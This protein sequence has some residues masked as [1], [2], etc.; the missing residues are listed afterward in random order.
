MSNSVR[1]YGQQPTRLLHP[2][3]SLGK[4]TGVGCHFLLFRP[5]YSGS[6]LRQGTKISLQD[7]SLLSLSEINGTQSLINQS[8]FPPHKLLFL[9]KRLIYQT[10]TISLPDK[11]PSGTCPLLSITSSA[12]LLGPACDCFADSSSVSA[13]FPKFKF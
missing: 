8:L 1:P 13:A 6:I 5:G 2:Q 11:E 7:C 12:R 9:P 10:L 4:N 3:D